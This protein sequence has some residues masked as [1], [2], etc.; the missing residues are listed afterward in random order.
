MLPFLT[1]LE[2]SVL[3]S[4]SMRLMFLQREENYGTLPFKIIYLKFARRAVLKMDVPKH[5]Q[6]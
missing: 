1:T 6:G 3:L 4:A 5:M 2:A